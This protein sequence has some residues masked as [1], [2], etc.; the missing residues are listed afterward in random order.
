MA[1]VDNFDLTIGGLQNSAIR[2]ARLTGYMMIACA[3]V[4]GAFGFVPIAGHVRWSLAFF[5]LFAAIVFLVSG[6]AYL[7]IAKQ[8]EANKIA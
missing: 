4:F 2:S 1:A 6:L 7:R 5:L 3:L 8:K